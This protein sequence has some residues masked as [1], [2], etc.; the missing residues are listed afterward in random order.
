VKKVVEISNQKAEALS[1]KVDEI[2]NGKRA[3]LNRQA[4]ETKLYLENM[5]TSVQLSKKLVDEGTDE[6]IISTQKMMLDNATIL[7]TK[8]E[9]YFKA[10]IPSAKLSYTS[11][12]STEPINAL[13]LIGLT[14]SLGEVRA[15]G[16]EFPCR[17]F[18]FCFNYFVTELQK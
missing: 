16:F 7:L 8:R 2:H 6:E 5:K 13:L 1:N 4:D 18:C 17:L 15:G 3:N 14:R 11:P 12:I 9:E 10:H